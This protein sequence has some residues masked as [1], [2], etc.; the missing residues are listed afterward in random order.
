[1]SYIGSAGLQEAHVH[2]GL[3]SGKGVLTLRKSICSN[4]KQL[5]SKFQGG[6]WQLSCRSSFRNP[7]PLSACFRIV[8]LLP[9]RQLTATPGCHIPAEV[10][11]WA[12]IG[13]Q[14]ATERTQSCRSWL[15]GRASRC[16]R[17]C[18]CCSVGE[19]CATFIVVA[20]KHP[21]RQPP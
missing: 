9:G 11:C 21:P 5:Q 6:I 17:R 13:V 16:L 1:M 19:R 10:I 14:T 12:K 4:L 2:H 15:F 18:L 3:T 7:C 8:S 20:P